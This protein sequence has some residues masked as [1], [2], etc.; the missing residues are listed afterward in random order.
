M[1]FI[2]LRSDTVTRPSAGMREAMMRAE[3][4]DDVF[5]EDPT[6]EKLQ[7]R[8]AE[9]FKKEAAL[10]VPSGTMGNEIC[11]K[12][13]TQP[14]EEVIVEQDSHVIIYETGGP[15]FLSQVQ[16][17][18]LAGNRGMFTAQQV[19]EAIRYDAYYMP[20]TSLICLENTHGRSAGAVLPIDE[21]RRVRELALAE[22]IPMHL[23]GARLWNASVASGIPV[24]E[25]AQCFDSLSV[26][27]SKGLGAPVG[28]MIVGSRDFIER[29]RKMRK[30]F[31]GGMRQIGIL[32]A[33]ALYA[34]DH[35][36]DRLSEDHKKAKHLAQRLSSLKKLG[37]DT[38]NVETNMVIMDIRKTGKTQDEVLG[39]LR[40]QGVLLTPEGRSS[41][42]AVTHLDVSA[43]E[44]DKAANAFERLFG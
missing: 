33:A 24:S 22:H 10:F 2:D 34:L 12:V 7:K 20:R 42:R 23:D 18:P 28:S 15:A 29:A 4:G 38:S 21:I 3:V 1:N 8:V 26:C 13:H 19:K 32:A 41:I 27:F 11:V 17:K 9:L 5:G 43:E 40:G 25:Y 31:G 6:A 35:N 36:V 39:M 37:V 14:G 30:I 16:L 44:V